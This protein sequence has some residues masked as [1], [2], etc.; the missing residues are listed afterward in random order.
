MHSM[1][2]EKHQ[3]SKHVI[4]GYENSKNIYFW[5]LRL[6]YAPSNGGQDDVVTLYLHKQSRY[7]ELFSQ[8]K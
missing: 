8:V 6:E 2:Q 1:T 3:Q 4:L 7:L 5:S